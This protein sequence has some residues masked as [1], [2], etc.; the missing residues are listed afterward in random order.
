MN[1]DDPWPLRK[2]MIVAIEETIEGNPDSG[3]FQVNPKTRKVALPKKL[4]SFEVGVRDDETIHL[5]PSDKEPELYLKMN[6][7]WRLG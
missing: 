5:E 7:G 6:G 4:Q 2:G 1:I 3:V